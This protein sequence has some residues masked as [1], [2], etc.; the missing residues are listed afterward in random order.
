M[1]RLD[2]ESSLSNLIG[3]LNEVN[4][5]LLYAVIAICNLVGWIKNLTYE[6]Y[7]IIR[8]DFLNTRIV[9]VFR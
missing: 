6:G 3:T 2:F 1:L 7:S 9:L 8:I 5:F 4:S